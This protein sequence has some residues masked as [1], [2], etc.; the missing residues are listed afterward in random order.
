MK[1][2]SSVTFY[3]SIALFFLLLAFL[4][5]LNG[6][7]A[8]ELSLKFQ[9]SNYAGRCCITLASVDRN[10]I[11]RQYGLLLHLSLLNQFPAHLKVVAQIDPLSYSVL[12]TWFEID[13]VLLRAIKCDQYEPTRSLLLLKTA[14]RSLLVCLLCTV[15]Y[16][17][18]TSHIWGHITDTTQLWNLSLFHWVVVMA[19]CAGKCPSCHCFII[20][21]W[22]WTA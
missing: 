12:Q 8:A 19:T 1:M 2:C 16:V 22:K 11:G 13:A 5:W 20:I 4:F 9:N 6:H 10:K 21:Q 14:A 18:S 7:I 17:S 15:H 3:E